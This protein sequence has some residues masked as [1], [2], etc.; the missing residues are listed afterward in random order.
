MSSRPHFSQSLFGR[1]QGLSQGSLRRKAWL[2]GGDEHG[3]MGGGGRAWGLQGAKE[4]E[5]H[6]TPNS[7]LH[8]TQHKPRAQSLPMPKAT[9][10][11]FSP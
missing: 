7:K 11:P 4:F 3:G 1:E 6:L 9:V 2:K 5:L 10:N 8:P